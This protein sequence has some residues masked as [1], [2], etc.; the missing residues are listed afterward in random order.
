MGEVVN[1][2]RFRKARDKAEAKRTAE[3]NRAAYGRTKAERD[4]AEK[5]RSA[6]SARLDGHMLDD[7]GPDIA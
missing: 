4:A 5:A 2:N 7:D 3:T 6:E 1:L